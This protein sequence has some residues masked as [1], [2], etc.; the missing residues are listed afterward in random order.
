MNDNQKKKIL[1]LKLVNVLLDLFEK[2]KITRE[3]MV[4]ITDEVMSSITDLDIPDAMKEKIN[5][6]LHKHGLY[7]EV[8]YV[9]EE[10]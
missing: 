7:S 4:E 8:D 3:Q 1:A 10:V 5:I 2:K 6:I 9:G